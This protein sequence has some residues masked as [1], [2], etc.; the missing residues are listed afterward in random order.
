M[1]W[2]TGNETFDTVV[3]IGLVFAAFTVLGGLFVKSPYGRFA[4]DKFGFNMN[5]KLGWWLMEIP[6]TAVF[7]IF[8]IPGILSGPRAMELMPLL[9]GLIWM[10]HYGNRGWFFPL[11][12]R[13]APGQKASFSFGVMA[14][15]MFVTGIHAY[16]NATFFT[17]YAPHLTN[18]WF[19]DPRFWIGLVIY[20]SGFFI[21]LQSEKIVRNLR[22][23]KNAKPDEPRYKIP[24]GGLY[25][26]VSSPQY[27]GEL[28]AWTGFA[29]MTWGLPGVVIFLISAGNLVPRAFQT[30][31]WYQEKFDNYPIDRKV[32]IPHVL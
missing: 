29:V 2:Y 3:T 30:H 4:S 16:M 26:Y 13:V 8:F 24:Y 1:N 22:D 18:E 28:I 23:P 27:L 9:L 21:I 15:G 19:S 5:P 31:R 32:I 10:I 25:D 20:Y 11:S 12:I 7:L 14:A 17:E 6:A